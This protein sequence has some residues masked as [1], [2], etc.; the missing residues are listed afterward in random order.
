MDDDIRHCIMRNR[1]NFNQCCIMR[2]KRIPICRALSMKYNKNVLSKLHLDK[3]LILLV[4]L[5][6]F[7]ISSILFKFNIVIT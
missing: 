5:K 3:F 7:N 1:N 6:G 2:L 4:Q